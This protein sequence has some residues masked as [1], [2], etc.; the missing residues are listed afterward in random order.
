MVDANKAT[1]LVVGIFVAGIM[2]A[3]LL[4]IAI[5]AVA[6]PGELTATQD[7]DETVELK[8]GLESNVTA[9]TAGTSA[10][11]EVTAGGDT[12]TTTVNVDAND[13]VTVDG[14]GV[15]ISP[16]NVTSTNATT[17]YEYPKTY[18][19]GGGAGAL[20][21]IIP[22]ILVLAIFLYF[23]YMALQEM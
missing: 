16:T 21:A 18:G 15:T 3:F 12:A 22:V 17:T 8:P 19:W 13:T 4:P 9:V 23:V 10:T 6:G 20:W 11:Y 1:K 7:V 5:G 2:A 14:A